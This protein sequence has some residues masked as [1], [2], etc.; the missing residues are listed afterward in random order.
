M[1]LDTAL[2]AG[3]RAGGL[4]R[5]QGRGPGFGDVGARLDDARPGLLQVEIG[6]RRLFDEAVEHR[7]A[8]RLPP[9]NFFQRQS[10]SRLLL[11]FRPLRRGFQ[12]RALVVRPHRRTTAQE[13][14][15]AD[16]P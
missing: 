6:L 14:G 13:D 16:D 5:R 15:E 12:R 11:A 1:V 3:H 8:E 4:Y 9:G 7:I 10:H 2:A